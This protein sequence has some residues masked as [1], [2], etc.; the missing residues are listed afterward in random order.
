MLPSKNGKKSKTW[1][2]PILLNNGNYIFNQVIN[3]LGGM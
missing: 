3:N 1:Y 2:Y